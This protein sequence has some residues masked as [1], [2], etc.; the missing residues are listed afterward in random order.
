MKKS[1]FSAIIVLTLTS[2]L[3]AGCLR[4]PYV[5]TDSLGCVE[6]GNAESI[7]LGNCS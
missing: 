6:V 3:M 2:L 7:Q 1:A 4:K 5:C